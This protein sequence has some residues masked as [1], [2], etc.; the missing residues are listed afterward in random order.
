MADWDQTVDLLVLGAG[1]GG[2]TAALVGADAGLSALV[3]EKTAWVGGTTAYSAG[4]A[5]IPGHHFRAD[6]P[7]DTAAARRYLDALVGDRAPREL[8]EAYL[9]H[10]P[11]AIAHLAG[12]GVEFWHS[13]T[14]VDYHPEIAGWGTGRALEPATFDGRRLG[15]ER[16]RTV[17]WP[18]PEFALFGGTMM[19]RRP[20]VDR[21]MAIFDGSIAGTALAARL[22]VRWAADRLRFPRGTRLTMGNALVANLYWQL[23]RRGGVVRTGA[24]ATELVREDG[25]VVGAIV[26]QAGAT[27]RVRAKRGIVLA[28]GGF[29]ASPEW[30]AVHLP[31][32][33]P[34]FTP[35]ADG[36]TGSTLVLAQRGGAALSEPQ[37]DNAVWFPSSIGRRKDGSEVVF[38]H[39]WDRAKPGIV[40]VDTTGGRFVDESVS[41]HRF[42]RAMYATGAAPAWLVI[43]SRS[44]ARYG[45]GLVRPRVPRRVLQRYVANG[46]LRA[47]ATVR[48]LA[49]EIGVDP[50][51]L[52]ETVR[53]T[54]RSAISGIDEEFGK[55]E[56]PY[57][58][59][60][61]DPSHRP[62]PNVGPI[63][64]APFYAISV[65]PT[66]LATTLGLRIDASARVLDSAAE[67]IPGLYACG[68]D[69]QSPMGSE[70]PGAGCQVG[71]ALT[72]GYRA[73]HHAS[74]EAW[75]R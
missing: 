68:N 9:T 27:V 34:A 22:G 20:E 45:L 29:A 33:T 54:N 65:V 11:A 51:G 37:D 21:L 47:G 64:T 63:E 36:A 32:P 16:F 59:Q 3:L 48:D 13:A 40:A 2:L 17:R 67:P 72:F 5:W 57:G 12:L 19:L 4:T 31:A 6:G 41:Y 35:A 26:D 8:R 38:P 39:I 44:L 25:R 46:Y 61:G 43:D 75:C 60:Y 1:A 58:R 18:I 74:L 52:E 53:R 50:A 66:P 24:G 49:V 70:Y 15:R 23:V 10:G 55:G 62:N 71:A 30:R 7:G 73:A 56:S 14:V 42:V 69:A 28:G